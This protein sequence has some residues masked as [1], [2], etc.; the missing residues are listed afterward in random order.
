MTSSADLIIRILA[1][2][3][4]AEAGI[5]KLSGSLGKALGIGALSAVEAEGI[6]ASMD[7][8]SAGSSRPTTASTS[9]PA[10]PGISKRTAR[11]CGCR[12]R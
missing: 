6:Q 2:T 4:S 1:D 3:S 9:R 10:L 12:P 7:I 11:S 8:Q 5:S